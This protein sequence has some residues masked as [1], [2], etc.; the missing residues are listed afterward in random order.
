M[1]HSSRTIRSLVV[2]GL[3]F[4]LC[5]AMV[6][7]TFLGAVSGEGTV[8][9]DDSATMTCCCGTKD[10]K[11]CG[12]ACCGVDAPKQQRTPV[13]HE[14]G[15]ELAGSLVLAFC[16]TAPELVT[17]EV[18]D[19]HGWNEESAVAGVRPNTLQALHVLLQT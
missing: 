6:S 2:A 19:S 13:P 16:Q 4:S 8:A 11:C 18:K 7:P 12:M 1:F 9:V 5:L 10:G 15:R 3:I 17:V 14:D